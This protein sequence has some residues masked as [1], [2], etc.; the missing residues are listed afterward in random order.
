MRRHTLATLKRG[1]LRAGGFITGSDRGV[2]VLVTA[3]DAV[4]LPTAALPRM[5]ADTLLW[6]RKTWRAQKSG[7]D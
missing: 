1:I 7:C 2:T 3:S 4:D 5:G 6:L